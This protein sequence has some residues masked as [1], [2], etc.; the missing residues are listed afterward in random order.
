LSVQTPKEIN[1][2]L[3]RI[4]NSPKTFVN[5]VC[6]D[7]RV[8][9]VVYGILTGALVPAIKGIYS[10]SVGSLGT[11][12]G[13]YK[14]PLI[15][16]KA[17]FHA[18]FFV[19]VSL[20]IGIPALLAL[21]FLA[22]PRVRSFLFPI[23]PKL[24]VFFQ[25]EPRAIDEFL[26]LDK[27]DDGKTLDTTGVAIVTPSFQQG[28]FIGETIDSVLKQNIKNLQYVVQ[29]GGSKD[30][31]V[32]VLK[33]YP[34]DSISWESRKDNGQTHALNLGFAKT[35][36]TGVMAYLNSDDLLLPNSLN[37]VLAFFEKNPDVDVVYGNRLLIDENGDCIGQWIL[38]GHD[39]RVLS[40]ADYVPQETMFWRSKLWEKVGAEFDEQFR[41]AMDWELILRFRKAGAKFAHIDKYLGAF[42]IHSSQKTSSIID[43]VGSQEMMRLRVRELGY[44]P[45]N[46]EIF[47]N[48]LPFLM[49]HTFSD[50][51]KRYLSR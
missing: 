37:T 14:S 5:L 1:P 36:N 10:S 43:E 42:R 39:N 50:F 47:L 35:D 18:V 32:E 31:T 16:L 28:E 49:R 19:L 3:R 33:S 46:E 41:F 38:H 24:G 9:K 12:A 15:I 23:L 26:S 22:I 44:E 13:L 34:I 29:D 11:D 6:Y 27:T 7:G 4:K 17:F 45:S 48:T 25:H 51:K 21:P 8:I 40:Y 30:A 20:L 2:T